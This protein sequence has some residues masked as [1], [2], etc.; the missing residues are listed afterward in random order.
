MKI[1]KG[2]GGPVGP[3]EEAKERTEF[4]LMRGYR[5]FKNSGKEKKKVMG[6]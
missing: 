1:G 6:I 5:F 2:R 4:V 3:G